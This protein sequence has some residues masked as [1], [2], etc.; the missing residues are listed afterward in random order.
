MNKSKEIPEIFLFTP[1][2]REVIGKINAVNNISEDIRF[3]TASEL[4][5]KIPQKIYDTRTYEYVDN[6]CYE[7]IVEGSVLYVNDDNDY[8]CF[9]GTTERNDYAVN[10]SGKQGR[11]LTDLTLN[12][13]NYLDGFR[14]KDEVELFD[15]G[16]KSGYNWRWGCYIDASTGAILDKSDDLSATYDNI[17]AYRHYVC[18]NFI[19]VE[20]G[21]VVAMLSKNLFGYRI[22][23]YRDADSKTYLGLQEGMENHY[24]TY[25]P[26]GRVEVKFPYDELTDEQITSGYIRVELYD[27]EHKNTDK[28]TYRGYSPKEGFIKVYSGQRYCTSFE[29]VKDSFK[30]YKCKEKWWVVTSIEEINEG[31]IPYKTITAYSYEYTLSK[32]TFSLSKGT[33]PLYI[34]DSI[35]DVVQGD[36]WLRDYSEYPSSS[37]ST[38]LVPFRSPQRMDRGLLNQIL[39]Y[40]PNWSIGYIMPSI[41][42]K[43]RTFD[44]LDNVNLYSFLTNDVQSA[45]QCY[46]VFDTDK[47]L[48]HI[49]DGCVTEDSVKGI[50]S[51]KLGC[52]SSLYLTWNNA[53]KQTNIHT[54]DSRCVTA[55]RVHSSDD[56]YGLG[57]INPT[58]N[59][60]LYNFDSY[61]RYMD[62]IADESKNR[63]L[64]TAIG[65][66]LSSINSKKSDYNKTSKELVKAN[67]E[68]VQLKTKVS[69]ALTKYR[70]VADKINIYLADDYPNGYP[71][72]V[73]YITDYPLNTVELTTSSKPMTNYENYHS[74]KLY[75]ELYEAA[76]TYENVRETY[77][78]ALSVYNEN[79]KKM[80]EISA[81]FSLNY[82]IVKDK[83][84]KGVSTAIL[85]AK[86]ILA[87]NDFIIEG[88]W[89]NENATFSDTYTESDII[90]TLNSVNDEAVSDFNSFISKHCYEFSIDTANILKI[91][92]FKIDEM[93]LGYSVILETKYGSYQFPVCMAIH[94]NYDDDT[95]FS[96]TF[97][98]DYNTKPLKMKFTKLFGT[99]NQ[100]SV[101]ESAWTFDE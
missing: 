75:D 23:Y 25:I 94:I 24:A 19:P 63:T 34:P 20:T 100:T 71:S 95:D 61:L 22:H 48:I 76:N 15:I 21:D 40:I 38:V 98:T 18:E 72:G 36:T 41:C 96:F 62:F 57:L 86:E 84:N 35:V 50:V 33:L 64:A 39:D 92:E 7:D 66:Y 12:Q 11:T 31:V 85:S 70:S 54:T 87:L 53:I 77:D 58:G 10:T 83:E 42:S 3:G 59:N 27:L 93:Y 80:K 26:V 55:L 49:I 81:M 44:D 74:K 9:T 73:K 68:T 28:D 51:G 82:K 45:Y 16:S 56:K 37:D 14:V 101:V 29:G 32:K 47:R 78:T 97:N 5:F 99:I 91:D 1:D 30:E 46:F 79:Y 4:S 90:N 65:I 67:L 60:I 17:V 2:R 43:Y 6:Q 69:E 88:D 89:T 8:F 13:N 52:Q